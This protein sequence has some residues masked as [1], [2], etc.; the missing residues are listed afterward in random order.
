MVDIESPARL[1]HL[2]IVA[3]SEV[4][5]L[6]IPLFN[7]SQDRL[8]HYIEFFQTNFNFISL[9]DI[10]PPRIGNISSITGSHRF[11]SH[12][13]NSGT[14][15]VKYLSDWSSP[16]SRIKGLQPWMNICGIIG[17]TE[18]NPNQYS[19]NPV[20]CNDLNNNDES[21]SYYAEYRSII[22]SEFRKKASSFL[23][24]LTTRCIAFENSDTPLNN[25]IP[26]LNESFKP[27][28]AD[29]NFIGPEECITIPFDSK[30]LQMY[31]SCELIDFVR[32][33]L[34]NVASIQ[35]QLEKNFLQSTSGIVHSS[36]ISQSEFSSSIT[37]VR[38]ASS[39]SSTESDR[40]R[41]T[42]ELSLYQQWCSILILDGV[43]KT[44]IG[45][46]HKL[47][48]DL[49]LMVGK[50]EIAY[51]IYESA[52]SILIPLNDYFWISTCI[53]G[54]CCCN[55]YLLAK[56]EGLWP[57]NKNVIINDSAESLNEFTN[58][59][60]SHNI[61]RSLKTGISQSLRI[62]R[63]AFEIVLKRLEVV[64]YL[65]R[66]LCLSI[67]YAGKNGAV[68]TRKQSL[69]NPL[70]LLFKSSKTT[71]ETNISRQG[72]L[73]N[74]L[75]ADNSTALAISMQINAIFAV[76]DY[77]SFLKQCITELKLIEPHLNLD[78]MSVLY[79]A[80]ETSRNS[81]N[82]ELDTQ[83]VKLAAPFNNFM[84]TFKSK[85]VRANSG[86]NIDKKVIINGSKFIDKNVSSFF[87]AYNKMPKS[88]RGLTEFLA[89][90]ISKNFNEEGPTILVNSDGKYLI[91]GTSQNPMTII[92]N[93]IGSSSG[94]K[95]AFQTSTNMSSA[96]SILNFGSYNALGIIAANA[97]NA[98]GTNI[99]APF[100]LS[101]NSYLLFGGLDQQK[102]L[103]TP[104]IINMCISSLVLKESSLMASISSGITLKQEAEWLL[105]SAK[106]YNE[107]NYHKKSFF[108]LSQFSKLVDMNESLIFNSETCNFFNDLLIDPK[109]DRVKT[110]L[111]A[112]K[113]CMLALREIGYFNLSN[114]SS[115]YLK[116]LKSSIYHINRKDFS[117]LTSIDL[118][119][120]IVNLALDA[121]DTI[122][123]I[124]ENGIE[125]NNE[126][127]LLL[128]DLSAFSCDSI[129]HLLS[130]YNDVL[131]EAECL[132]LHESLSTLSSILKYDHTIFKRPIYKSN[133]SSLTF[134]VLHN[135]K[136][137]KQGISENNIIS[138][139]SNDF[140]VG[141]NLI[142]NNSNKDA[143]QNF[144]HFTLP[145]DV[146]KVNNNI[147]IHD[148]FYIKA[149]KIANDSRVVFANN[150]VFVEA[151]ISNPFPI[152][153][154]FTAYAAS[155]TNFPDDYESIKV[156]ITLDSYENKKIIFQVNC[157]KP[158]DITI[159]S[160]IVSFYD[161]LL[162][163]KLKSVSSLYNSLKENIDYKLDIKK[164]LSFSKNNSFNYD[165]YNELLN[166]HKLSKIDLLSEFIKPNSNGYSRNFIKEEAQHD[167]NLENLYDISLPVNLNNEAGSNRI[168]QFL[169]E[170]MFY[171][172]IDSVKFKVLDAYPEFT[173]NNFEY[174]SINNSNIALKNK[175]SIDII[176]NEIATLYFDILLNSE[177]KSDGNRSILCKLEIEE[178]YTEEL[179]RTPMN[180][181]EAYFEDIYNNSIRPIWLYSYESGEYSHLVKYN[182]N[183][184]ELFELFQSQ[185]SSTK[186]YCNTINTTS[187]DVGHSDKLVCSMN[188]TKSNIILL[189]ENDIK[190][191]LK[192]IFKLYGK[193][194][195]K[196]LKIN[197]HF[198]QVDLDS[199]TN[200]S[201]T[202]FTSSSSVEL[203]VNIIPAIK[204]TPMKLY[205]V[206]TAKQILTEKEIPYYFSID[207]KRNIALRKIEI[208]S[209]F[210]LMVNVVNYLPENVTILLNKSIAFMELNPFEKNKYG[211]IFIHE[212]IVFELLD[213]V[214][215][216]AN[217]GM[218]T[219]IK[220]DQIKELAYSLLNR[221]EGLEGIFKHI[222]KL[223]QNRKLWE[224][225][226]IQNI[227]SNKMILEHDLKELSSTETTFFSKFIQNGI[228]IP[229]FIECF[230][231]RN[232]T[233]TEDKEEHSNY[234]LLFKP[235]P[236][237]SKQFVVGRIHRY[238]DYTILSVMIEKYV[239][240]FNNGNNDNKTLN[241]IA[242]MSSIEY[243]EVNKIIKSFNS[244]FNGEIHK[245]NFWLQ[246]ILFRGNLIFN[247]SKVD[248]INSKESAKVLFDAK[249]ITNNE[250][251]TNKINIFN[252]IPS[253]DVN[254][255]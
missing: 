252:I 219:G 215:S 180:P 55:L 13:F 210:A 151:V 144:G 85:N 117:V 6:V 223:N 135:L 18:I 139:Q 170:V 36:Y 155:F 205:N 67:S 203:D 93:V 227:L 232:I 140:I 152:S 165:D 201:K 86:L 157:L 124:R 17:I 150:P 204:V 11:A 109:M 188:F 200:I 160:V 137:V 186:Q 208:D 59:D 63:Y 136:Y 127:K 164:L 224:I 178:I 66:A 192:L 74:I 80:K 125:L 242:N 202:V 132:D 246:E 22:Y 65:E 145:E 243:D 9:K 38:T 129:I 35:F 52:M 173:L 244:V 58:L 147:F 54:L 214:I 91:S 158:G 46:T 172:K 229:G 119:R 112:L 249:I 5:I 26:L 70:T 196:L 2:D 105:H 94:P 23:P 114:I 47:I 79:N 116:S 20:E 57:L 45:R 169:D 104:S 141:S 29:T 7:I 163:F 235:I 64:L 62:R 161:N 39:N 31:I 175:S 247:S 197:I 113:S 159:D 49:F 168:I 120:L 83:D 134:P 226:G 1:P 115:R 225:K 88:I 25:N 72:E 56:H 3:P 128:R 251:I 218:G 231:L 184:L 228:S 234:P 207:N 179:K 103:T 199:T 43:N 101:Q 8:K 19:I 16:S 191:S 10:A 15:N 4:K 97:T 212:E 181:S 21:N 34:A 76:C 90:I 182:F 253:Y 194:N 48:A 166:D 130:Y 198:A 153:L 154:S 241:T 51:E 99:K 221:N 81:F 195:L 177:I 236:E 42:R 77:L 189:D 131:N 30:K 254:V 87:I 240:K 69:S 108:Y 142:F 111:I 89:T 216:D 248:T 149:S 143:F 123:E 102:E 133:S 106:L 238:D 162:E 68:Y 84:D 183:E 176:E 245:F 37:Q 92:S 187:V 239:N 71:K 28:K 122:D 12:L 14:L 211:L 100:G 206:N 75:P 148:P 126:V 250:R 171:N 138:H 53:E 98:I 40:L 156:D 96:S 220:K 190:N 33:L 73:E 61:L 233:N 82:S 230:L 146:K 237:T 174:S 209:A 107:L 217:T 50:Y 32:D 24:V 121:T 44:S 222:E 255:I 95:S 110:L 213:L 60:A 185:P 167:F 41:F 78:D 27:D 118:V 193:N